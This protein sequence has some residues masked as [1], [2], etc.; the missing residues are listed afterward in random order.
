MDVNVLV[1]ANYCVSC[2]NA[3]TVTD[4]N[5]GLLLTLAAG[6]QGYFKATTPTVVVSDDTA[7]VQL[8]TARAD[9]AFC[10]DVADAAAARAQEAAQVAV[11]SAQE[12]EE[13]K[14]MPIKYTDDHT[15]MF[16]EN[17]VAERGS[18]SIGRE[19]GSSGLQD[20]NIGYHARSGGSGACVT[21]GT[22][23]ASE[24][25]SNVT[26]G[27][28]SRTS[29]FFNI[30]LGRFA[31]A[32]SSSSIAIGN[33]ATA[34]ADNSIALGQG[35]N[36]LQGCENSIAIGRNASCND[37]GQIMLSSYHRSGASLRLELKAGDATGLDGDM[38]DDNPFVYGAKFIISVKDHLDGRVES[39][40]FD[41]GKLFKFLQQ[42]GAEI[43]TEFESVYGYGS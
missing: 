18:V 9:A 30:A 17:S 36:V 16:G 24:G 7:T 23:A 25:G 29:Y 28:N 40:V 8:S 31:Q 5:G 2:K 41:V 32:T 21:I 3:C 1:G 33:G 11:Q 42:N 12:L 10:A 22:H 19:S 37:E 15:V 13:L 20:V 26:I 35:A 39:C 4:A 6:K 38:Q 14:D 43:K 34:L 27:I